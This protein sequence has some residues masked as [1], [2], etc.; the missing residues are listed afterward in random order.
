MG[1]LQGEAEGIF[2]ALVA[3]GEVRH[4]VYM[5]APAAAHASSPRP[6]SGHLRVR[7][8][9]LTG[10]NGMLSAHFPSL[11]HRLARAGS[12]GRS[13][14]QHL[15]R[16]R[17]ARSTG[18]A[19]AVRRSGGNASDTH[20]S[21]SFPSIPKQTTAKRLR[22]CN[23]PRRGERHAASRGRSLPAHSERCRPDPG[24]AISTPHH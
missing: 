3:D 22:P 16:H 5:A 7:S 15:C 12:H 11:G 13:S 19:A 9:V 23:P 2:L 8:R 6:R 18:G 1:R 20:P 4:G 21:P 24:K 17:A 14:A 10:F